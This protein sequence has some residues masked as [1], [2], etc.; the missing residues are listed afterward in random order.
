MTTRPETKAVAVQLV[1]TGMPAKHAATVC[2]VTHTSVARWVGEA[3]PPSEYGGVAEVYP[4]PPAIAVLTT[5]A[6]L[7]RL[8][9]VGRRPLRVLCP[10]AGHGVYARAVLAL[11][12]S[13][14]VTAIEPRRECIEGLAA[15]CHRVIPGA[16][17]GEGAEDIAAGE[18][19]KVVD[20]GG[21]EVD[22]G[23]DLI[24]DNPPF[25]W[26]TGTRA[27]RGI[28]RH[29][30]FRPLL[31]R[32]GLLALLGPSNYGHAQSAAPT[33]QQWCPAY[34]FR[35]TGRVAF[36]GETG[37]GDVSMWVWGP[38]VRGW[39]AEQLPGRSHWLRWAGPQPGTTPIPQSIID[40]V[41]AVLA[42]S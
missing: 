27:R 41:R 8:S 29:L 11:E 39:H 36:T 1:R 20:L 26:L 2:G 14:V 42:R 3:E 17:A 23:Y 5:A 12:P 21:D 28:G 25:T 9:R 33:L 37:P 18:G 6:V 16:I 10:A 30:A 34:Q 22:A 35:I 31:R 32:G 7:G 40:E 13:A 15:F 4:T 24:I 19:C 38:P